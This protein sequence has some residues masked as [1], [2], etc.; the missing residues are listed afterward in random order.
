MHQ[1]AIAGIDGILL[2]GINS[3]V[4]IGMLY[5]AMALHGG[6][7]AHRV[8]LCDRGRA[9]DRSVSDSAVRIQ[10]EGEQQ[11][12]Y[13]PVLARGRRRGYNPRAH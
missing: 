11:A 4:C 6:A 8:E 13:G 5:G 12:A 7:I 9:T 3:G 10:G 1:A 2:Y